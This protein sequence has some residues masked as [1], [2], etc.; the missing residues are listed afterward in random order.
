MGRH[1]ESSFFAAVVLDSA[2]GVNF[3]WD[4]DAQKAKRYDQFAREG[5]FS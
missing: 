2:G 5:N 3:F 1:G 4:F